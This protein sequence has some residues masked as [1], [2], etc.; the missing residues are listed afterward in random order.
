MDADEQRTLVEA[1]IRSDPVDLEV[2]RALAIE[3]FADDQLRRIAWPYLL[4]STQLLHQDY[5]D[6]IYEHPYWDQVKKDIDRSLNFDRARKDGDATLQASR[7]S[8]AN[9]I[10]A[11]FSENPDL[12]YVQGFHDVCSVFFIVCGEHLGH[13]LSESLSKQHVR[14]SLRPNLDVVVEVL[15]LIFPL[16]KLADQAVHKFLDASK[17]G[18]FFALSWVLTWFAHNMKNF[19]DVVRLY[20]FFLASHPLMPVYFSVTV[21]LDLKED[22]LALECEFSVLHGFFQQLPEKID[23][24]GAIRRCVKLFTQFPPR[25]LR[26]SVKFDAPDSSP[27]WVDHID[28]LSPQIDKDYKKPSRQRRKRERTLRIGYMIAALIPVAL[29]VLWMKSIHQ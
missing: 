25:I 17:V 13:R 2:L 26:Q 4:G 10:H 6:S 23:V 21:I 28:Q 22:I 16:L 12:H 18:S 7:G 15:S 3:G 8:L 14:D 24:A 27:M 11:I 9:I 19:D 5:S 20:D 1:A 29:G